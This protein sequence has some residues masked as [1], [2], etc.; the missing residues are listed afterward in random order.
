MHL[1]SYCGHVAYKI[2]PEALFLFFIVRFKKGWSTLDVV[3]GTFGGDHNRWY[4]GW[5]W[6]LQYLDDRYETI[7]GHQGL[8]CLRDDFPRFFEAIESYTRKPKYHLYSDGTE[9]TS[10]QSAFCPHRILGWID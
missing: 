5:A 3:N 6:M 1:N 10:T 2:H 4:Y 7:I 8:L 9:F